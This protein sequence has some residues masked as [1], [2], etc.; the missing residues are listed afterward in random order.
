MTHITTILIMALYV[1]CCITAIDSFFKAHAFNNFFLKININ[2]IMLLLCAIS[3][4]IS[5]ISFYCLMRIEWCV[6]HLKKMIMLSF[7]VGCALILLCVKI[8]AVG[9]WLFNIHITYNYDNIRYEGEDAVKQ[10]LSFIHL[11]IFACFSSGCCFSF[12]WIKFVNHIKK[13]KIK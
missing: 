13:I 2:H 8:P 12:I 1:F 9:Q 11:L 10:G 6:F 3:V 5:V 4:F 7:L